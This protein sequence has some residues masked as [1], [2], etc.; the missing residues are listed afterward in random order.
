MNNISTHVL[1]RIASWSGCA[2][3]MDLLGLRVQGSARA[4]IGYLV[5]TAHLCDLLPH[6]LSPCVPFHSF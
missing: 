6:S 5:Q 1:L 2:L 3:E 4:T